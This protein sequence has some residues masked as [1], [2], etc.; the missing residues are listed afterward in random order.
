MTLYK[1]V[2]GVNIALTAEEVIEY[3][4]IQAAWNAAA[5]A[6]AYADFLTLLGQYLDT[7]AL[8]RQYS[9]AISCATYINSTNPTWSAEAQ[10]FVS[11]RDA[12][13]IAAYEYQAEVEGGQIP[14][15]SFDDFLN[16]APPLVWP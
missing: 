11:W 14:D 5:T 7:K 1:N 6:R 4:Q 3:E 10:A 13:L 9:S 2:D 12:F 16:Q 15:P 8:E